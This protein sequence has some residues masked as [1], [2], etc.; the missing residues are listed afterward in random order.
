VEFTKEDC[1]TNKIPQ[2]GKIMENREK[3]ELE[4][5]LGL[6]FSTE[7]AE[8][9]VPIRQVDVT[10]RVKVALL[11]GV[12]LPDKI[13][14]CHD[15]LPTRHGVL[16]N[17]YMRWCKQHKGSKQEFAK[18]L[19]KEIEAG[20]HPMLDRGIFDSDQNKPITYYSIM[21]QL[22]W[23]AQKENKVITEEP[24]STVKVFY[25]N[26]LMILTTKQ[27]AEEAKRAKERKLNQSESSKITEVASKDSEDFVTV[28]LPKELAEQIA[29][30]L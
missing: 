15:W 20:L 12:V 29:Q 24:D 14:V 13:K 10:Y 26:N 6:E 11:P 8:G 25:P 17:E 7:T 30:Y 16:L 3:F 23:I 1:I 9:S 2:K 28:S 21:S 18:N 27:K 4:E 19:V 22:D 5:Q